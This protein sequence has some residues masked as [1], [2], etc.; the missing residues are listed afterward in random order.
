MGSVETRLQFNSECIKNL[1]AQDFEMFNLLFRLNGKIDELDLTL[2]MI[3]RLNSAQQ[4]V[5]LGSK[6]FGCPLAR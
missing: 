3:K 5:D 4:Y 6:C 2:L 1:Q